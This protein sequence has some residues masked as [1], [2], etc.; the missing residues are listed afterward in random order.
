[1]G[2]V[3][4]SFSRG[5]DNALWTI[6]PGERPEGSVAFPARL[7]GGQGS[8]R[9]K[10]SEPVDCWLRRCVDAFLDKD[11]SACA[12][13]DNIALFLVVKWKRLE[14]KPRI[15]YVNG[16][17]L[18]VEGLLK[19]FYNGASLLSHYLRMDYDPQSLG[20]MFKEPLP[21][22]H[23]EDPDGEPRFA[24]D[25]RGA[26]DIVGEFLDFVYRNFAHD[27]WLA[28]ARQVWER[29]CARLQLSAN[30][31]ET[32]VAAYR[33]GKP[34]VLVKNHATHLQQLKHCLMEQRGQFFPL[35]VDVP[36]CELL[37]Y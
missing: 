9:V 18:I 23:A 22:I 10:R 1:M 27:L 33:T 4:T 37:S 36:S 16:Q 31:F 13:E 12:V 7:D 11:V 28:W 29:Q 21:H 15:T 14:G 5:L 26:G 24:V 32:I 19:D 8:L 2:V 3:L 34:D 30:P 6:C 35:R 20:P 17:A 25:L